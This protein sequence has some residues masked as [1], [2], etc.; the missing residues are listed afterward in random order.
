[1][2]SIMLIRMLQGGTP[3]DIIYLQGGDE[4]NRAEAE[5]PKMPTKPTLLLRGRRKPGRVYNQACC[6]TG[7]HLGSAVEEACSVHHKHC[8]VL[9]YLHLL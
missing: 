7:R 6:W 9:L 4:G 3:V 2:E 1:M 8:N 5:A